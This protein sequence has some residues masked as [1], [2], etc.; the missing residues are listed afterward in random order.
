MAKKDDIIHEALALS[1]DERAAVI[2]ELV[3]SMEPQ[4]AAE[5]ADIAAAWDKEILR[6][7][8]ALRS[9]DVETIDGFTELDRLEEELDKQSPKK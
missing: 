7:V 3:R 6:R 1:A 4:P 2:Y 8:G 9:G 5:P